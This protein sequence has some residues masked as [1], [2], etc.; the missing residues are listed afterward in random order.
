[1][2]ELP[3]ILEKLKPTLQSL[4]WEVSRRSAGSKFALD[5]F[6][7]N[8]SNNSVVAEIIQSEAKVFFKKSGMIAC[9]FSENKF[10]WSLDSSIKMKEVQAF[11]TYLTGCL[12]TDAHKTFSLE[13]LFSFDDKSLQLKMNLRPWMN[14]LIQ[15]WYAKPSEQAAV[16]ISLANDSLSIA[17]SVEGFGQITDFARVFGLIVPPFP[18]EIATFLCPLAVHKKNYFD[19]LAK[20]TLLE[21]DIEGLQYVSRLRIFS[22]IY[23]K[24]KFP[25]LT[26]EEKYE[27]YHYSKLLLASSTLVPLSFLQ[28]SVYLYQYLCQGQETLTEEDS[29][30]IPLCLEILA[31]HLRA[32]DSE[33]KGNFTPFYRGM[34][35]LFLGYSIDW[36]K[37]AS[38]KVYVQAMDAILKICRRA[39]IAD[40]ANLSFYK[41]MTIDYYY[42]A[43]SFAKG[44]NDAPLARKYLN[45]M[46]IFSNSNQIQLGVKERAMRIHA[47]IAVSLLEGNLA[48]AIESWAKYS[49]ELSPEDGTWL[50]QMLNP[51]EN[52]NSSI[53]FTTQFILLFN[54]IIDS[55]DLMQKL[56]ADEKFHWAFDI[57]K[58]VKECNPVEKFRKMLITVAEK[59]LDKTDLVSGSKK[60]RKVVSQEKKK[61]AK[62]LQDQIEEQLKPLYAKLNELLNVEKLIFSDFH[63][64]LVNTIT[65]QQK[66]IKALKVDQNL[67]KMKLV[68]DGAAKDS[69]LIFFLATRLKEFGIPHIHNKK[70]NFLIITDIVK[71]SK[72]KLLSVIKWAKADLLNSQETIIQ[73]ASRL[74]NAVI[75]APQIENGPTLYD[76]LR[77]FSEA[78]KSRV[79]KVSVHKDFG[80]KPLVEVVPKPRSLQ[81]AFSKDLFF[82]SDIPN[83]PVVALFNN[84]GYPFGIFFAYIVRN[85]VTDC[86]YDVSSKTLRNRGDNCGIIAAPKGEKGVKTY[87]KNGVQFF[88]IKI[89]KDNYLE[90]EF[91]GKLKIVHE[92]DGA[93]L[94]ANVIR[95][96]RVSNHSK[97]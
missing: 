20:L 9:E 31:H 92:V 61:L 29:L 56:V 34:V 30:K 54:F 64:S 62:T 80:Q 40:P 91:D 63:K 38:P 42:I 46:L 71:A 75:C 17:I 27:A 35:L 13:W 4:L 12:I 87:W 70:D 90:G 36:L 86:L 37:D 52:E 76:F 58:G 21:E 3:K 53:L 83:C 24:P 88:K 48:H 68:C 11:S 95:F 67:R 49:E 96:D 51:E 77:G 74:E 85:S 25:N 32:S 79:H 82:D 41:K 94:E 26:D 39:A 60:T 93:K 22:E 55:N 89:M 1:M 78:S 84:Y 44:Q 33:N 19:M 14:Q 69:K 97:K 43:T 15:N 45:E 65:D 23:G 72:G 18:F 81:L 28:A 66:E 50:S 5:P 47:E 57:C 16:G 7:K 6:D 73:S 8:Q 59:E 2:R 10:R